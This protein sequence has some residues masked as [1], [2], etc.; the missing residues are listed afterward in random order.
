MVN[1]FLLD[2][3][4]EGLEASASSTIHN[5]P[6]EFGPHFAVDRSSKFWNSAR[7]LYPWLQIKLP[8]TR[9]II[10]ID[11]PMR[12]GCCAEKNKDIEIRAGMNAVGNAGQEVILSDNKKVGFIP[13][14]G[15]LNQV[16]HIQFEESVTAAYITLQNI[17]SDIQHMDINEVAVYAEKGR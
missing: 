3:K 6:K 13:G 10:A 2:D 14:P 9:R 16:Y 1:Y 4:L 15:I 8:T 7:S 11:V 12:K 17:N 5:R